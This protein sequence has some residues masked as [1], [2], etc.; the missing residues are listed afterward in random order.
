MKNFVTIFLLIFSALAVAQ[1]PFISDLIPD[2]SICNETNVSIKLGKGVLV[3][4]NQDGHITIHATHDTAMILPVVSTDDTERHHDNPAY[5][6]NQK[7]NGSVIIRLYDEE[8]TIWKFTL[9]NKAF[10]FWQ[11][12][13][14]PEHGF[15]SVDEKDFQ[16]ARYFDS[17]DMYIVQG[18]NFL[19]LVSWTA[20]TI[21]DLNTGEIFE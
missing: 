1:N 17:N 9:K 5:Q 7:A 4:E 3:S 15:L 8:S 16:V 11:A 19:Y 12:T 14:K 6:I 21:L 20:G 13:E 10:K 2:P 18:V